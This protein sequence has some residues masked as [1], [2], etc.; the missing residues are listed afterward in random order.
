MSSD[1]VITASVTRKE[2]V[3]LFIF[4]SIWFSSKTSYTRKPLLN[5]ALLSGYASG[6]SLGVCPNLLRVGAPLPR[7]TTVPQHRRHQLGHYPH[8]MV[9]GVPRASVDSL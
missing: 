3:R 2:N 8:L 5:Y 4:H 1:C 9:S 7:R 6:L